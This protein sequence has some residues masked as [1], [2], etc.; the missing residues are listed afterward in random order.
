MQSYLRPDSNSSA[1]RT[2]AG[3]STCGRIFQS[4]AGHTVAA[5]L[6]SGS[7]NN[8]IVKQHLTKFF[9][10]IRERN[11]NYWNLNAF[12][13]R[14]TVFCGKWT[15]AEKK[16][17]LHHSYSAPW[18]WSGSTG[19]MIS[20]HSF[21]EL[22]HAHSLSHAHSHLTYCPIPERGYATI[23]TTERPFLAASHLTSE[24]L[25]VAQWY[26]NRV[27]QSALNHS[28]DSRGGSESHTYKS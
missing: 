2:A 24:D 11:Y 26:T 14:V 16:T 12:V 21:N 27:S 17:V 20:S 6:F 4:A 22:T 9:F 8:S 18:P 10:L 7:V 23:R 13:T 25:M 28:V 5:P 15:L 19:E 3:W 1:Q